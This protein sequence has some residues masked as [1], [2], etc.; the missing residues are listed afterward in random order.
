MENLLLVL[1]IIAIGSLVFLFGKFI[2]D[3]I[4]GKY[5]G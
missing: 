1:P 5:R 2:V 3:V 4:L